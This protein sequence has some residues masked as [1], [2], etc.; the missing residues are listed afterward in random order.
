MKRIIGLVSVLLGLVMAS[1]GALAQPVFSKTFNLDT[2]GP[3]STS[4][5]TFTIDNTASGTP[6]TDLAFTDTYPA[7]VTNATPANASTTCNL[8][9][10]TAADGGGSISLSGG[11]VAGNAVCTLTVDVTSTA[12]GTHMNTSGDLTSSAGNSGTASDDLTVETTLPGFSK[13]FSPSTASFNQIVTLTF[14]IDNSLNASAIS[15]ANFSDTLPTGLTIA[16]TPNAS[17]TCTGGTVTAA[18]GGTTVSFSGVSLVPAAGATCTVSVEVLAAAIGT[19][20]NQSGQLTF[21]IFPSLTVLSAG[22]ATAAREVTAPVAD[23]DAIAKQFTNDPAAPGSTVDLEFTLTNTDR[24]FPAT[25][26]AFS[27]D[28]EATLTG[29]T[30]S[31]ALPS[32]PCGAGS[33]LNVTGTQTLNLAAGTLAAEAMCTFTVTLLVPAG[34]TPGTSHLNTTSATSATI[35]GGAAPA[36]NPATDTLDIGS[37]TQPIQ[38]TKTF[39][40]AQ[41]ANASAVP[42]D[43]VTI[44]FELTNPNTADA[45]DITFTD[46]LST[47]PAIAT[48]SGGITDACGTGGNVSFT[49][50]FNPP[51]PSDA[52]QATLNLTGGNLLAGLSCMFDVT[53]TLPAGTTAG[54]YTNT[55]GA[56]SATISG[57]TVDG[58]TASDDLQVI[59]ALPLQLSKTFLQNPIGPGDTTTLQFTLS[60]VSDSTLATGASFTDDLDAML[61]GTTASNLPA[62]D[63]CG[64]GSAASISG[65]QTLNF[66]GM[67]LAAG[68]NCVFTADVTVPAGAGSVGTHTNTTSDLSGPGGVEPLTA[69]MADLTVSDATPPVLTKTFTPSTVAAGGQTV[70]EFTID[71]TA[72]SSGDVTAMLFFDTLSNVLSGTPDL[73][74]SGGFPATPCGAGSSLSGSL[75]FI[76]G[77]LLSGE[78]CSF[79]VTLD[80]PAGAALGTHTNTTTDLFATIDGVLNTGL[81]GATAQLTVAGPSIDVAPTTTFTASGNV[82]GAFTPASIDYTITNTG[83]VGG[84]PV[85]YSVTVPGGG[86]FEVTSGN[87]TGTIP[88]SGNVVVTVAFNAA[89]NVLPAGV[90]ADDVTFT[91]TTNNDGDTTRTVELT[92]IG[93]QPVFTKQFLT[94][95][96]AA[97]DNVVLRFTINNTTAGNAD[98][99]NAGFS[100]DLSA[101]LTGLA[102]SGAL[103][104]NPCGASSSIAGT[105]NLVLTNAQVAGGASCTFDVT[106]TVPAGA[107]S[108]G[109]HTNTTSNLTEN[110]LPFPNS[111]A[112]ATLNVVAAANLQVT[113]GGNL[114]SSGVQASG[115]YTPASEVYTL[116]NTGGVSLSYTVA[117]AAG[118]TAPASITNGAGTIGAGLSVMVTV[119]INTAAADALLPGV[120]NST[121][122]FTNTTNGAGTQTRDVSLTIDPPPGSLTINQ[123]SIDGDGAFT[124]ASG[125]AALNFVINTAGGAGSQGPIAL[126]A[127]AFVVTQTPPA[128]FATTSIT[129]DDGDSTGAG[130]TLTAN[131]AAGEAVTCT[132][133]S[134]EAVNRTRRLIANFIQ[135]RNDALLTNEPDGRRFVNRHKG[136]FSSNGFA[137]GING[138]APDAAFALSATPAGGGEYAFATSLSRIVHADQ[139]AYK[140]KM[141]KIGITPTA[142][143]GVPQHQT[144]DIWLEGKFTHYDDGSNGD[145]YV[146]VGYLGFDYLVTPDLLLGMLGS[147]DFARQDNAAPGS[148]VDGVGW[149]I[150]PYVSLRLSENLF[151]YSRAAWGESSNNISPFGTY[152]DKFNSERWLVRGRLSGSWNWDNWSFD[153]AL[154]AAYIEDKAKTYVDS[155]GIVIAGQTIALGQL[156]FD[157][158]F[159]YSYRTQD[160]TYVKTGFSLQA[161]W[162][163]TQKNGAV[164]AGNVAGSTDV[165]GRVKVD[166]N[167][168]TTNGV[169]VGLEGTY[170]GIGAKNFDA[171][172]GSVKV[173]V[174]LN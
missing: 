50:F 165:R 40:P 21:R 81:P 170:D 39:N 94:D 106:L 82:G 7:G 152:V 56:V 111:A 9:T 122:D 76:G 71:N 168:R 161:L 118:G 23:S 83:P 69:A 20:I 5:L 27:D 99:T 4:T 126:G 136:R 57:G 100:D 128:G 169:S 33:S 65:T 110:G 6:V 154:S 112:T 162:N 137:G 87:A 139:A 16:P 157:P 38:L 84:G 45:T 146:G 90:H 36:G 167:V 104:A 134:A 86:F 158:Y 148:R 72:A 155:N 30:V 31:G 101:T 46:V 174:P 140:A 48:V 119:S 15:L 26:I 8:G 121:I 51:P 55:T 163:F 166:L 37:A 47:I 129:C 85:D 70:L 173:R 74:V 73:T 123:V 98:L 52:I 25:D 67:S 24:N 142:A 68:A 96:V 63:F 159:G 93:A 151:F 124:F 97:G 105:T 77:N 10:V 153:P 89:A 88:E 138:S 107:G 35:N 14:T 42:G 41:G 53:F 102:V 143:E 115:T 59:V 95:P 12:A 172:G 22:T 164:A 49:P 11:T 29:L 19:H 75:T 149:L 32:N 62:N 79:S 17:T 171:I 116:T 141:S 54:T 66:T 132:F 80:V 1:S 13:A 156:K 160:G 92:V 108:V 60:N 2:I 120:F 109:N 130:T 147:I 117:Q 34:A 125:T 44:R 150:G 113:P 131:I 64:T 18:G 103:P 144:F 135:R 133:T 3:G 61:A 145:G 91:N 43:T 78:T 58:S 28:L 114:V 127:G